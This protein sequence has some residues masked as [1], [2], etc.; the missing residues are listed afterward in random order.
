MKTIMKIL[1]I[2]AIFATSCTSGAFMTGSGG[3]DDI[4]YKPGDQPAVSQA[5]TNNSTPVN[6]QSQPSYTNEPSKYSAGQSQ[7]IQGNQQPDKQYKTD[8]QAVNPDKY[9]QAPPDSSQYDNNQP[10]TEQ[11][12]DSSGNTYITNNYYGDYNPDDYYNYEYTARLRRFHDPYIGCGY[13]DNYYTNL[14]WYTYD[15]WDWGCS[16]YLGYSWWYPG[17]SLGFGFGWGYPYWGY[18][19][20]SYWNGYYGGY[21]NPYDYYYNSYDG[22]NYYHYGHRG[23][24]VTN[25]NNAILHNRGENNRGDHKTIEENYERAASISNSKLPYLA[26]G[27]SFS[28]T[29]APKPSMDLKPSDRQPDKITNQVKPM[30]MAKNPAGTSQK[31][32]YNS[33]KSNN[34]L[35]TKN[36]AN[37]NVRQNRS[38]VPAN[39]TPGIK[40]NYSNPNTQEKSNNFNYS[41]P[42]QNKV[43]KQENDQPAKTQNNNPN[44]SRNNNHYKQP[45]QALKND[46]NN[47]SRQNQNINSNTNRNIPNQKQGQ[48]QN[49]NQRQSY[50]K[51]GNSSRPM[52]N[53]SN[54]QQKYNKS[55][56][57]RPRSNYNYQPSRNSHNSYGN[58]QNQTEMKVPSGTQSDHNG[59]RSNA[60]HEFRMPGSNSSSSQHS[61]GSSGSS[62]SGGSRSSG[63]SGS[64]G[65]GGHRK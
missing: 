26:S 5:S 21:Y 44:Y 33:V 49:Q 46:K 28:N 37:E 14:Y 35:S 18:G 43:T 17:W 58:P 7:R 25:G 8:N 16:L 61:S 63:T 22:T 36:N 23:N 41:K 1:V 59:S 2:A 56:Y 53:R 55:S 38:Q 54:T 29:R 62:S 30:Q 32:A 12:Q 11:Y 13:Y 15:P 3:Y 9:T 48:G 31:Q 20:Y 60:V 19:P 64:S 57:S 51:P 39:R 42:S 34:S 45:G 47:S 10:Y 40:P 6:S 65:S 52:Y 50:Q 24:S 4:Y 27:G